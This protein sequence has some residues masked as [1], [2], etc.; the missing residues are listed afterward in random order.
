[1]KISKI[2]IEIKPDL[3]VGPDTEGINDLLAL[4]ANR[5]KEGNTAGRFRFERDYMSGWTE[6]ERVS[7]AIQWDVATSG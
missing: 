3:P 5:I 1:M 6:S 4:I 2:N 7:F